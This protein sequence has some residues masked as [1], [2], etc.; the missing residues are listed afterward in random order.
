MSGL[1]GATIANCPKCRGTVWVPKGA[2]VSAAS[3]HATGK[4]C[5]TPR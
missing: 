2:V 5:P 1:D 4:P 3:A